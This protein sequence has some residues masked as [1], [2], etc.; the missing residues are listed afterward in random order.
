[1][2]KIFLE[3]EALKIFEETG[4][5]PK[6]VKIRSAIKILPDFKHK[7]V[8]IEGSADKLFIRGKDL[9]SLH[10]KKGASVG[11]IDVC[12]RGQLRLFII[13]GEVG[14]LKAYG[15]GKILAARICPGGVLGG[16]VSEDSVTILQLFLQGVKVY[17]RR[18]V[19]EK[20]LNL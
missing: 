12:D 16:A 18:D 10:I 9:W 3:E 14:Y 2:S 15:G 1:M 6:S 17:V 4:T 11:C 8:I 7:K 13:Y 5:L 19:I 20:G